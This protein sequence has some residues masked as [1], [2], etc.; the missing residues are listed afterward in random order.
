MQRRQF[1][2]SAAA[3][4]LLAR[5][6]T[7]ALARKA[8]RL[9]R[10]RLRVGILSDIHIKTTDAQSVPRFVK[11]LEWFRDAGVDAV[12]IAGDM[13]DA[14][15]VTELGMVADAWYRVFPEDKAPDGSHVEKLFIYGN[16]DIEGWSYSYVRRRKD[17]AS[18]RADRIVEDRAAV[19]EK[20]F[21]EPWSPIY[22]KDVKGYKFIGGHYDNRS[23]MPGLAG[24]LSAHD[25]E[26][27]GSGKPFFYF[28]HTHPRGTC[29]APWVWGQDGGEVTGLLSAY[30][31]AVAF[32][33]H[34]HTPLTDDRVV[35]QGGFTS[36]GTASLSY[37]IPLGGR[38]N[39]RVFGAKDP[40][41]SQMPYLTGK[42]AHHGQLMTVYDDYI[43][44]Q[45]H[46]FEFD[47]DLGDNWVIPLD[48]NRGAMTFD[49][50]AR[51]EVAPQFAPGAA[52]TTLRHEGK[53]R[54]NQNLEQMSV[55]FPTA[56]RG[57]GHGRAFDYEVC[58]EVEDVD[59]YKTILTKRVYSGAGYLGERKDAASTVVCEFG[60][61]E[62]PAARP[63]RFAVRPCGCFGRKGE[64][65]LSDLMCIE[66]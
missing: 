52:V 14:G 28:Q 16:H 6:D 46:E 17:Y 30:P 53:D 24:F 57:S 61:G 59:T 35:W 10:R 41:P 26:L 15:T 1:L 11:A 22:I 2:Q 29:S 9:G 32:S 60:M 8:G 47:E 7:P 58:V 21:H 62:L 40:A 20:L 50:R 33:G 18:I 27:S 13:A 49:A 48:V 38:E 64:A 43:V 63:F 4:A 25:S 66:P 37:V 23:N 39:S 12:L 19:W 42:D 5:V 3:A 45:R 56:P 51:A 44:L 34:S 36:I 55:S 31:N 65:L 54:Q